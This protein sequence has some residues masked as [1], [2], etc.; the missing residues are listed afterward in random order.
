MGYNTS[1]DG[2]IRLSV[3]NNDIDEIVN[4]LT[5]LISRSPRDLLKDYKSEIKKIGF[6]E[7]FQYSMYF[8]IFITKNSDSDAILLKWDGSEKTYNM[9]EKIAFIIHMSLLKYTDINFS[10]HMTAYGEDS[11]D[12]WGILV[13]DNKVEVLYP[14][15]DW[16]N[17]DRT[18]IYPKE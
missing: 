14:K 8:D 7:D 2:Y 18:N 15:I 13:K 16:D 12:I 9:S 11:G 3:N 17:A 1:F 6:T 10:G 5:K 4:F